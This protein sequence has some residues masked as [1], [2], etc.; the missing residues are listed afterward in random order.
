MVV[1]VVSCNIVIL[2]SFVIFVILGLIL[3]VEYIFVY[4][5]VWGWGFGGVRIWGGYSVWGYRGVFW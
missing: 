3:R 5:G 4:I 1:D 2:I